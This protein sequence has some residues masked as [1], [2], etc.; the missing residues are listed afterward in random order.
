V[1][2]GGDGENAEKLSGD[3]DLLFEEKQVGFIPVVI[4]AFMIDGTNGGNISQVAGC[5]LG[6]ECKGTIF[7]QF[8]CSNAQ[9]PG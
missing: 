6:C 3:W 4:H 1:R 7:W 9:G 8:D 2:G 5:K